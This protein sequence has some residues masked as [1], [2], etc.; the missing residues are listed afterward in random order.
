[1]RWAS[2]LYVVLDVSLVVLRRKR[3]LGDG[4]SMGVI[5]KDMSVI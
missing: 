2:V 1:V 4:A 5:V 3:L